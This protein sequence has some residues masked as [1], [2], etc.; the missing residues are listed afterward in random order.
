MTTSQQVFFADLDR[1]NA[2]FKQ[3]G[4]VKVTTDGFIYVDE[5]VVSADLVRAYRGLIRYGYAS[6]LVDA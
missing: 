3:A 5:S 6:G 4:A 2:Q 1:L